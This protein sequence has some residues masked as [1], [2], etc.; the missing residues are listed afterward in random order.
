MMAWVPAILS[1]ELAVPAW[2]RSSLESAG[3]VEIVYPGIEGLTPPV[4]LGL[5]C[6]SRRTHR[7]LAEP[8]RGI[9]RHSKERS[10]CDAR[11]ERPR[12]HRVFDSLWGM[13]ELSN[14]IGR[15]SDPVCWIRSGQPLP[16]PTL[17]TK[18]LERLGCSTCIDEL[19]SQVLEAV[20]LQ[21]VHTNHEKFLPWLEVGDRQSPDGIARAFRLKF[22]GLRVRRPLVLFRCSVTGRSGRDRSSAFR[23]H[24]PTDDPIS[25]RSPMRKPTAIPGSLGLVKRFDP[26]RFSEWAFG[27]MNIPH[28]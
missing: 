25:N 6:D 14:E 7:E 19:A 22:H 23:R 8:D 9:A 2:Q 16:R 5:A 12:P 17:V 24:R 4:G 27:Q 26:R 3:L 13:D 15:L 28:S 10:S 1:R 18:L 11:L 20:F 21:L